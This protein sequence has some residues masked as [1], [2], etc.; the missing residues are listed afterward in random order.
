V[1]IVCEAIQITLQLTK[2][3]GLDFFPQPDKHLPIFKICVLFT[4]F[5]I[6][7]SLAC[8]HCDCSEF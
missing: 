5:S 6:T 4:L 3:Y 8:W 7:Y 2:R 1:E